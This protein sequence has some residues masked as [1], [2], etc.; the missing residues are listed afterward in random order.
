MISIFVKTPT[1]RSP[2]GS[3][4][5]AIFKA[6]EVA[7]SALAAETANIMAFGLEIYS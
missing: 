5:A 6:A 3:T 4:L 2:F 7:R 1:V